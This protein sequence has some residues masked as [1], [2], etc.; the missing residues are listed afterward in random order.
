MDLAAAALVLLSSMSASG[1]E[2][3]P[4]KK[5]P[6]ATA[7]AFEDGA[8]H[9]R[10]SASASAFLRRFEGPAP[11]GS[12]LRWRWKVAAPLVHSGEREKKGDDFAARVYVTFRYDPA[13]AGFAMRSKYRLAK[14]LY[15]E[16]PPH[17]G[18]AYV[19]AAHEP[20]G[21]SWP[22]PYT[23][24]VRMLALRS[25]Q[26]EA[27]RWLSEVRDF[28]ADYRTLFGSEPPP[29]TGVAVMSDS[30]GT[31]ASAEAWFADLALSLP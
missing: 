13:K 6:R 28:R 15:G 26:A 16:Y 17:A 12:T 4:F 2:A 5:V 11:A 9:A 29:L 27:G 31:G 1:W 19:W 23:D 30:D 8:V 14:A 24:R 18:I 21:A 25:G 22:N 7:Y 3:R 20:V 10:S